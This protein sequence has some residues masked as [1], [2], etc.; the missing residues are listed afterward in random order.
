MFVWR[1]VEPG[2]R[3][4]T[5]GGLLQTWYRFDAVYYVRI[6]KYGYGFNPWAPAFYPLYPTLIKAA[7]PLIPGQGLVAGMIISTFFAFVT[8]TT[9]VRVP[10]TGPVAATWTVPGL[11][12]TGIA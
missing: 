3:L 4:P 9:T 11:P 8:F 2:A 12:V 5:V 1:I 6:A 10:T 7:D